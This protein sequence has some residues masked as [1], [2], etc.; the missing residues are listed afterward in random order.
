[1]S[2]PR[3]QPP[4]PLAEAAVWQLEQATLDPACFRGPIVQVPCKYLAS[5]CVVTPLHLALSLCGT[6][7]S[8]CILMWALFPDEANYR[9]QTPAAH[10]FHIHNVFELKLISQRNQMWAMRLLEHRF[11]YGP[12]LH[13]PRSSS[14]L[15]CKMKVQ[16]RLTVLLRAAGLRFVSTDGLLRSEL[17]EHADPIRLEVS[18]ASHEWPNSAAK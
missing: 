6:H 3:Q 17:F 16:Q 14:S 13:G 11:I 8:A 5:T 9:P 1:M 15:T 4:P 10:S 2:H 7:L 18:C 12:N